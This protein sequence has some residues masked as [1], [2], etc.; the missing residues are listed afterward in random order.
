MTLK[1]ARLLHEAAGRIE[2]ALDGG[3]RLTLFLLDAHLARVLVMR[4]GGLRMERTWSP[5]PELAATPG[6]AYPLRR[7]WRKHRGSERASVPPAYRRG[8]VAR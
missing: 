4:P 6:A 5:S 3:Y 2:F 1:G 8:L 7:R